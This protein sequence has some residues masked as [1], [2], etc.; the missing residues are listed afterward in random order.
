VSVY[1]FFKANT[2]DEEVKA[3]LDEVYE[4]G[5]DLAKGR[6]SPQFKDY[7]NHEGGTLSLSDLRGKYVYIDVWATWCG[8][9]KREIPAL[10]D[11]EKQFDGKNIVFVSTSIDVAKDHDTWFKMVDDLNLQ[12]IQLFA[13]HDWSSQFVTDYGIE[14]I[15]RFILVDPDGNIVSADAPRPSNPRLIELFNSL[16]I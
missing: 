15:P 12:G 8:P 4:K 5:K 1:E 16:D 2:T 13:D 9:C 11:I 6:P 14:G 7:E 10:K 3:H